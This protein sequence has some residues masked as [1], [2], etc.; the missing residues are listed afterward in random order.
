M[1]KGVPSV[2]ATAGPIL[3]D[4]WGVQIPAL[5]MLMG[6]AS[7]ILVRVMLMS[8]EFKNDKTFWYYNV[9]LT[10]L[11]TFIAFA[12]IADR[13]LAPGMAVIVGTGIG[14]SGMVLVDILKDRV[15]NI[16]KAFVGGGNDP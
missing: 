11:M 16:V 8:K 7:V 6:L 9:A 3:V 13:Q 12:I 4:L 10:I 1:I 15:Q 2:V 5:S 14:A